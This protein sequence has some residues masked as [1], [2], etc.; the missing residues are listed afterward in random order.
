MGWGK[1]CLSVMGKLQGSVSHGWSNSLSQDS[2]FECFYQNAF[3]SLG[4]GHTTSGRPLGGGGFLK[5][6]RKSFKGPANFD[7]LY[8]SRYY[9]IWIAG[10][11]GGI[12]VFFSGFEL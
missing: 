11:A 12:K 1:L 2:G 8:R 9:L 4:G 6:R 7:I 3:I 5:K 10:L